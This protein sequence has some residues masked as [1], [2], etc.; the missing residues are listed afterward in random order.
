[1][2]F[3]LL[4]A[5]AIST[6]VSKTM[7]YKEWAAPKGT[8]SAETC[9]GDPNATLIFNGPGDCQIL[10]TGGDE[11]VLRGG[12]DDKNIP[13]IIW[14]KSRDTVDNIMKRCIAKD[15]TDS[16]PWLSL[17]NYPSYKTCAQKS[18]SYTSSSFSATCTDAPAP[19]PTP[20]Q[21]FIY[22]QWTS[23]GCSGE[24]NSIQTY[25]G[26][27]TTINE[28]GNPIVVRGGC[29]YRKV[30]YIMGYRMKDS[31][32]DDVMKV[33]IATNQTNTRPVFDVDFS[34]N[35][36]YKTCENRNDQSSFS[37]TCIDAPAPAPRSSSASFV[38]LAVP[39]LMITVLATALL[40]K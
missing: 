35:T 12:C 20:A 24:P 27:C 22:K 15:T 23:P 3:R 17:Q 31:T 28:N 34:T 1:M 33:C 9:S 39:E 13:Y 10:N 18:S 14:Y 4:N 6:V 7:I 37:A 19:A 16:E 40:S 25:D 29:D 2:I 26:D 36:A 8:T 5:I 32:V 30:P 38:S 11:I 21:Q